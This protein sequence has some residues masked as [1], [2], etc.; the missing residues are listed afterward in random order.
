MMF[1]QKQVL[2]GSS[3]TDMI[4]KKALP[5]IL[6]IGV[7]VMNTGI[8]C[9][10]LCLAG[11]HMSRHKISHAKNE[12][13]EAQACPKSATHNLHDNAESDASIKCDCSL[14]NEA[15]LSD[16]HLLSE[17]TLDLTPQL[18]LISSLILYKSSFMSV[19]PIPLESP[20]EILT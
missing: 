9:E 5:I 6:L 2:T 17:V 20:P 16:Q 8:L 7:L 13:S 19:E 3:Q 15:S 11:S 14:D 4:K 18:Y 12:S 1:S 10:S